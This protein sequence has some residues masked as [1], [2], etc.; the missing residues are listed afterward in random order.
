[1]LGN[2][3]ERSAWE[4]DALMRIRTMEDPQKLRA[5]M[6]DACKRRSK[7]MKE[8]AYEKLCALRVRAETGSKPGTVEHDVWQSIIETEELL[9]VKLGM[10]KRLYRTRQM[11]PRHGATMT[12]VRIVRKKTPSTGFGDLMELGRPDLLFESIALHHPDKFDEETKDIARKRLVEHGI[13]PEERT[14]Q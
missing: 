4:R 12:V 3:D 2:G 1:M 7:R 5:M 8:V 6:V 11:I 14:R 13:V 10:T 9:S